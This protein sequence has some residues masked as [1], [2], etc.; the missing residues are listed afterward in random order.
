M[1]GWLRPGCKNYWLRSNVERTLALRLTDVLIHPL[2]PRA[3]LGWTLLVGVSPGQY[4][5]L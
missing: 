2:F 4:P 3:T 1:L 5:V